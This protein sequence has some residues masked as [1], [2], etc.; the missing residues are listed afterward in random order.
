MNFIH[1]ATLYNKLE[2]IKYLIERKKFDPCKKI[3]DGSNCMHISAKCAF[4]E[5]ILKYLIEVKKMNIN[6]L[7]ERG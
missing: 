6:D 5:S 7:N 2:I 1:F 3:K 4:D